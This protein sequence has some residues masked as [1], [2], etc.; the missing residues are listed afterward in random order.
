M[1]GGSCG[2]KATRG[3]AWQGGGPVEKGA[4][5]WGFLQMGRRRGT[6]AAPSGHSSESGGSLAAGPGFRG[7]LRMEAGAGQVGPG[8]EDL[9]ETGAALEECRGCVGV[10]GVVNQREGCQE[11]SPCHRQGAWDVA[12]GGADAWHEAVGGGGSGQQASCASSEKGGA[13]V[14]ARDA[15]LSDES[16]DGAGNGAEAA[17]ACGGSCVDAVAAEGSG[18]SVGR[19]VGESGG[20]ETERDGGVSGGTVLDE[21]GAGAVVQDVGRSCAR[22]TEAASGN[23]S[24]DRPVSASGSERRVFCLGCSDGGRPPGS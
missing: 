11:A 10:V 21:P 6:G 12:D 15:G 5:V 8:E 9:Y 24:S 22:A 7:V 18:S 4:T 1:D 19:S 17:G 20:I 23:G 13:A 14:G 2:G 16:V 3:R